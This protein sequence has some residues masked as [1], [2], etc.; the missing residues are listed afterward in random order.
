MI[1]FLNKADLMVQKLQRV[2]LKVCFPE[3]T[4]DNSLQNATNYIAEQFKAANRNSQKIIS[5][6][7]TC[8]TDTEAIRSIFLAVKE[9]ILRDRMEASSL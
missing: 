7:L 3:Y 8:A 5:V 9:T 1:L 2:P 6:H 4:G